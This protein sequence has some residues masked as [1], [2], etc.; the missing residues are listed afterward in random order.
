MLFKTILEVNIEQPLIS[1]EGDFK[2]FKCIDKITVI[3]ILKFDITSKLIF[4]TSFFLC[5]VL[6]QTVPN[7]KFLCKSSLH[8]QSVFATAFLNFYYQ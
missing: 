3:Y 8:L 2:H 5:P 7:S 4:E 6:N 1:K